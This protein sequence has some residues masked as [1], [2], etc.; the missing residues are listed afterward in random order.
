[1]R[2]ILC[3]TKNFDKWLDKIEDR[4]TK[5]RIIR[6]IDSLA[7]GVFGDTKS[8]SQDLFELRPKGWLKWPKKPG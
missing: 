5:A 8:V 1:M 2:Y 3:S 7:I 4:R 6:R